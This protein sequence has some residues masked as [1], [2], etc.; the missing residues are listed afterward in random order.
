[1]KATTLITGGLIGA[2]TLLASAALAGQAHSDPRGWT[3]KGL[4]RRGA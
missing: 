3:Y 2:T 4:R 1:M